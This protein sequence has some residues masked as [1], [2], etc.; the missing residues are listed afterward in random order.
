M[1]ESFN[2]RILDTYN[3]NGTPN[4]EDGQT[5]FLGRSSTV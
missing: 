4:V 5:G 2:S 3:P 1:A